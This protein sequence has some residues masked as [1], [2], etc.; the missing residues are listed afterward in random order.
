MLIGADASG[1]K[2]PPAVGDGF[3]EGAQSWREL[4]LRLRDENGP[5]VDPEL[6]P[7]AGALGFRRAP[8]EVWPRTRRQ[9]RR[10]HETADALN[11]LPKSVHG[12]AE[13]D[14]RAIDG[15]ESRKEAEAAL[16]RFV[17]KDGP[18]Y[19][20][21]AACLAE[22][23]EALPAFH[24]APTEHWEHVGTTDPIESTFATVRPRT[25]GTKGCLSREAAPAM[26][27]ELARS[28]ERH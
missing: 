28:A 6:A 15:A 9:R 21:A 16:D 2:E 5:I 12:E 7:G 19:G 24:A 18:K 27:H 1:R 10:V 3:R 22:D 25:E 11:V 23:R 14:L 13:Q 8:H 4:L 20:K 17:A 26:V